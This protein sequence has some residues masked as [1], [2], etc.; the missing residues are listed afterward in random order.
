M[1]VH[2][3][4]N[5]GLTAT[6]RRVLK[7]GTAYERFFK[8]PLRKDPM[9]SKKAVDVFEV[10]EIIQDIVLK[11]KAQTAALARNL[12]GATV[13]ETASNIYRFLY[14]HIQYK[15]DKPGVEQ[16]RTPYRSW[17]DRRSGIDCDC[18]SVFASSIL[19]N[20]GIPHYCRII[21]LQ[22][23]GYY[24]H[25][26]VVVPRPG[27][28]FNPDDKS[29]YLVIDPVLST[30][31]EEAPQITK[32]YDKKMSI[33]V[34]MLNGLG[35]PASLLGLEFTE[36]L[37][38]CSCQSIPGAFT[39]QITNHLRNTRAALVNSPEKAGMYNQQRMLGVIDQTIASLEGGFAGLGALDALEAAENAAIHPDYLGFI[40]GYDDQLGKPKGLVKNIKQGVAKVKQ[41]ASKGN[42]Q[43]AKAE[44]KKAGKA[45]VRYSPATVA[46]RGGVLAALKVNMFG[47]SE[48]LKWAYATQQQ[49][50]AAGVSAADYAAAKKALAEVE[51]IFVGALQGK[52]ENL[53]AAIL[54]G[55][56]GGLGDL[57]VVVAAATA[58]SVAAAAPFIAKF[59]A[60]V[61]KL[62]SF[63]TKNPEAAAMLTDKAKN[64]LKRKPAT[65]LNENNVVVPDTTQPTPPITPTVDASNSVNNTVTD[66]PGTDPKTPPTEQNPAGDNTP[67]SNE[68]VATDDKPANKS[69]TGLYVALGAGALLLGAMA[70]SG[71]KKGKGLNGPGKRKSKA[72]KTKKA[73]SKKSKATI[74]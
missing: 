53:K 68:T 8:Q 33:P 48:K 62:K 19:T 52:A 44:A 36:G 18:F 29:T 47:I 7:P 12:K 13:E 1:S 24:Q 34:Q 2:P 50:T 26:Y 56:H 45:I 71:G 65:K 4:I 74:I 66:L 43:A 42:I 9:V 64:L 22:G 38:G 3:Y 60:I 69:N 17:A 57:G 46:A 54:S 32:F 35:N 11:T 14:D 51:K 37:E 73:T 61:E 5:L 21:E 58:T 72:R 15:I 41:A 16:I 28:T 30:F 31:N 25:I 49:L 40:A 59:K 55:K 23:K 67:T 6:H 63:K 10:L 20:L 70:M 39:K 27:K